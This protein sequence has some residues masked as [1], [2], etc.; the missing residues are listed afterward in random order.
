MH[1]A[2]SVGMLTPERKSGMLYG[3]SATL[4]IGSASGKGHFFRRLSSEVYTSQVGLTYDASPP[5]SRYNLQESLVSTDASSMDAT[6]H[7][8]PS[9]HQPNLAE[10]PMHHS[11]LKHR[12]SVHFGLFDNDDRRSTNRDSIDRSVGYSLSSSELNSPPKPFE[13]FSKAVR[14]IDK[15]VSWSLGPGELRSSGGSSE[16]GISSVHSDS[17]EEIE[18]NLGY[19]LSADLHPPMMPS[20]DKDI[21]LLA[22][23]GDNVSLVGSAP[24]S[25]EVKV[26]MVPG[27]L[28]NDSSTTAMGEKIITTADKVTLESNSSKNENTPKLVAEDRIHD[29]EG[30]EQTLDVTGKNWLGMLQEL[31]EDGMNRRAGAKIDERQTKAGSD[32]SE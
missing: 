30:S 32:D 25:D 29:N 5:S 21:D 15:N 20:M 8:P 31:E 27:I 19:S 6:E 7:L 4:A 22:D 24:R 28:K 16:G 3:S 11:P 12:K 1:I 2:E 13:E 14:G 18:R 9:L 26:Q 23:G 17:D 10:M